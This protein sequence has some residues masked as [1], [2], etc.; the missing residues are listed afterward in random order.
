MLVDGEATQQPQQEK[1]QQEQ[2]EQKQSDNED[3]QQCEAEKSELDAQQSAQKETE[4][5]AEETDKET[6]RE[7]EKETDT[8][9]SKKTSTEGA[10]NRCTLKVQLCPNPRKIMGLE[11][12]GR[13]D[14]GVCTPWVC[15]DCAQCLYCCEPI[16]MPLTT[17][18]SPAAVA[19]AAAASRS[20]GARAEPPTPQESLLQ[21]VVN[22]HCCNSYA[23]GACCYPSV[24]T[25]HYLRPCFNC[26]CS[27]SVCCTEFGSVGGMSVCVCLWSSH[28]KAV[29]VV[30]VL[31]PDVLSLSRRC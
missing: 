23:H 12:G 15:R 13:N 28:N 20:A 22:C 30:S 1:Q 25:P 5:E 6:Q 18:R 26:C 24:R 14:R 9:I 11:E 31:L 2:Q 4:N 3:R 27:G 7:T 10:P 21:P 17:E 8:E 29:V 16:D 19:A